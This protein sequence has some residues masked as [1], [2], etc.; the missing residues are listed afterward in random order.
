MGCCG[1]LTLRE[2]VCISSGF[3][4]IFLMKGTVR[5]FHFLQR[6]LEYENP[7]NLAHSVPFGSLVPRRA[8]SVKGD[9]GRYSWKERLWE[10]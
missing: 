6:G 9:L 10:M 8:G 5:R 4:L 2:D 7:Q 3:D 1:L